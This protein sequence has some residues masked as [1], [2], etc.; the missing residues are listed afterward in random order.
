MIDFPR[1]SQFE[2]IKMFCAPPRLTGE[3]K[4]PRRRWQQKRD[5]FSYLQWETVVLHALNVH[6]SFLDIFAD[7]LVLSTTWNDP[8][9]SCV[10]D[11][12][13]WWQMVNFVCL[14]LKRWFQFDSWK[15]RTHFAS[16]MA[17]NNWAIISETFLGGLLAA[18]DVVFALAPYF[19][20]SRYH[21]GGHWENGNWKKKKE[22]KNTTKL[23]EEYFFHQRCK[24]TPTNTVMASH[25][26]EWLLMYNYLILTFH[27][28]TLED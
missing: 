15:A 4:Q 11:V 19:S 1:L 26:F 2:G 6:F 27:R 12:S 13:I 28:F 21:F 24:K 9:C 16:I 3:L 14:S 8:F 20:P 25:Y 22:K 5:N 17:M 18:A 10:D 7:V 23:S